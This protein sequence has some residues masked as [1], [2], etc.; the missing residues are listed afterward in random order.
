MSGRVL[1]AAEIFRGLAL[2]LGPDVIWFSYA[3]LLWYLNHFLIYTYQS[4][5]LLL[6]FKLMCQS[7]VLPLFL[8]I[9]FFFV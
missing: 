1:H 4:F 2:P 8:F 7:H 6:L 3:A 9:Y 5:Y